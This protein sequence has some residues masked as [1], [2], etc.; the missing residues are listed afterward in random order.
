VANNLLH[1]PTAFLCLRCHTGHRSPP[2]DHF[3]MG[4]T[5]IDG[6]VFQRAVLYTD[7][8]QCHT[9]VH[10]SDLPSQLRPGAFLR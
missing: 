2:S 10:G 4:T 5:D 8:T 3:G 1:Q 9:H 6:L 7:C